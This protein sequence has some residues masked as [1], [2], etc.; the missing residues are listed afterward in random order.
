M[1]TL[2]GLL[3]LGLTTSLAL[4]DDRPASKEKATPPVVAAGPESVQDVI[5]LGDNRPI[6]LRLRISLGSRPFR[7][8]WT[9]SVKALHK[10][11]DRNADGSVTKDEADKGA[12]ATL[13]RLANGTATAMPRTDLDNH[14][15]DGLVSI[16]ELS[17]ALQT[18]LGPFRVQVGKIAS[19]K[20]DALFEQLDGD[21]SGDLTSPELSS[22]SPSLRKLDLDDDELIGAAELEPFS[23]PM[24]MDQ[25]E[26]PG[27]RARLAPVP[28]VLEFSPD[29]PTLRPVRLL[30]KRYDKGAGGGSPAGDNK[31]SRG[32][33][34]VD[35]KAFARADADGDEAL[36]TEE[37]R[38]H[39]AKVTPDMEL[40]VNLSADSSGSAT[41]SVVGGDGKTGTLPAGVK[42]E[43]L[44]GGDV[45]IAIDEVRLE[46]HV[47]DGARASAEAKA[48]FMGQFEAADTDNNGYLEK[49][50][51]TKDKDHPSP[52]AGLFD[53]LDRDEDGKLY[54]KEMDSFVESQAEAAKSRMVLSASDQGRAIFAILDLNRDRRLGIRELRA[55][56]ARVAT[57]DRDGDGKITADE[58]PHH[59]QLTLGRGGLAGLGMAAPAAAVRSMEAPA[60]AAVASGPNW[61]RKMD[62]NRDGDLSRREFHGTRAQFDRLDGDKDDL[63]DAAEAAAVTATAAKPT[64]AATVAG[65]GAK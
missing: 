59:Y 31:L 21:K 7:S 6:F 64:S 48:A 53:L 2:A 50:E 26:A 61:F 43:Q 38:R 49:S 4:G 56:V 41:V 57:W 19:G 62:R 32:E 37:L 23:N 8:A 47:D 22:A 63:I 39:L 42:V 46:V 65:P 51:L 1:K 18:A 35:A 30:I 28:P 16:E 13:V 33:F 24:A 55:T 34:A 58:I 11:L 15:K 25:E 44:T 52:L 9:D 14:P 29:D 36:D 20:A 17:D 27:R 12:L 3:A 54:P 10:F 40:N 45:E 60:P 5:F